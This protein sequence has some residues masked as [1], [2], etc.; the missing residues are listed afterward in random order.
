MRPNGYVSV[1]WVIVLAAAV[2]GCGS[3]SNS[4]QPKPSGLIKRVFLTNEQANAVKM[5][6]ALKDTFTTKNLGASSPTKLVTAGGQTLVIDSTQPNVS[7]IDNT[8]ESV[9]FSLLLNDV[10]VDVAITS[11]GKIAFAA[12]RNSN[13]VQFATTADGA[14]SPSSISVPS[15]RRMVMSP[16]GSKLLVF[17]DPQSQLTGDTHSFFV[18]DTANKGVRQVTLPVLDQPFTAV[19]GSND[20]QAFILNCAGECG[21]THL[22]STTQVPN[23]P[24]VVSVDFSGIFSTPAVP[25]AAGTA[26]AV[27]GATV[28]LLNGTS[29]FVA[30]TPAPGAVGSPVPACPLSRCGTLSVINTGSL[31]AGTAIPITDGLHEK[32]ALAAGGKLYIGAS[33]C[34]V[35]PGAA[36]NTV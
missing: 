13:A 29:L 1:V 27:P 12:E 5:L 21:T 7:V 32:M 35:E 11:D 33:A 31:T 23:Q 19:F 14:V 4:N 10:P 28:G 16:N 9:T 17:S 34:T 25:A 22:V 6:D 30:G 3:S 20:N 8:K 18:I 2:T 24:S 36:P 26:V 15:P